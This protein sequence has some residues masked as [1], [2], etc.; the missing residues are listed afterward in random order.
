M[1]YSQLLGDLEE[2]IQSLGEG[3][4][5]MAAQVVFPLPSCDT[6]IDFDRQSAWQS[7]NRPSLGS[8][9]ELFP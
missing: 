6:E 8:D 7:S 3:S 1:H 5:S 4:R 2:R 9:S